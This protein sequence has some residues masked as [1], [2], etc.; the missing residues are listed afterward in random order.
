MPVKATTQGERVTKRI[1]G[2]HSG[3]GRLQGYVA[4]HDCNQ[5][6]RVIF[7]DNPE[8]GG[9][10]LHVAYIHPQ[11]SPVCVVFPQPI[12]FKNGLSVDAGN[13]EVNVWG[14]DFRS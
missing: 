10:I 14:V 6:Q 13:C 7:Y 4:G 1:H 9:T 11:Q 12:P 8:C 5:T 2:L 3:A